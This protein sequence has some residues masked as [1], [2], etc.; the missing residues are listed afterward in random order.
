[1]GRGSEKELWKTE[2]GGGGGAERRLRVAGGIPGHF[3]QKAESR[4][5]HFVDTKIPL[6]SPRTAEESSALLPSRTLIVRQSYS[7]MFS[8]HYAD[9][10]NQAE[11]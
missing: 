7:I 9:K 11:Q 2:G 4:G 10:T 1:M 5:Y 8:K 6:D 3:T